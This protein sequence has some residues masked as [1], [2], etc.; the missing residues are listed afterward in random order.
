MPFLYFIPNARGATVTDEQVRGWGLGHA[1]VGLPVTTTQVTGKGPGGRPGLLL[2]TPGGDQRL[3]PDTQTWRDCGAFW[4]GHADRP[5]AD[6]LQRDDAVGGPTVVL[7]DG[8][9]WMVPIARPIASAPTFPQ[10][11]GVDAAGA[12]QVRA[13]ERF[14][15][16]V[17][18]GDRV[19]AWMTDKEEN[20]TNEDVFRAAARILGINYRVGA[21]ELS[22]LG[23]LTDRNIVEI[24]RA[25]IDFQAI[26]EMGRELAESE[27]KSDAPSAPAGAGTASGDPA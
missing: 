11:L 17:E 3:L 15:E 7:E 27:K 2:T 22:A 14:K 1:L 9:L 4:L 8:D 23:V 16:E 21:H 25:Y 20:P 19:F 5:T 10:V 18:L 12:L 13:S 24:C 6:E 26:V